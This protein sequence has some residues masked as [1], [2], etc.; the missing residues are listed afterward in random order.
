M[1]SWSFDHTLFV[2]LANQRALGLKPEGSENSVGQGR[3]WGCHLGTRYLGKTGATASCSVGSTASGTTC[4]NTAGVTTFRRVHGPLTSSGLTRGLFQGNEVRT[5][6]DWQKVNG[7]RSG[8][9]GCN[10]H[11]SLPVLVS[12]GALS[13]ETQAESSFSEE[14]EEKL[15]VAFSL[16]KQDLHLVL[17]TISFI[18]E[19]AV[20]HNLKPASLQQQ[21]Q[22]IH[23]D[24]DKAEAFAS[25]WAAAGQDTIEKFRQRVLTPQKLE[26][27]GWQLNL[28]MA[29]SMQAKLKSPRAVL[30][31][32]VSNEDSKNLKKVFVEFSHQELFEFYNKLETIQAQLDSLT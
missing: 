3:V 15:Q 30:E 22:S 13:E 25:A 32:G 19:Q 12:L 11:A 10:L 7:V 28:Q 6:S 23:L 27:I 17:E 21:L 31:L 1:R 20:Y 18:L 14:E 29:E 26:T 24:Q 2:R 4:C 8:D 16:E 9:A 5:S